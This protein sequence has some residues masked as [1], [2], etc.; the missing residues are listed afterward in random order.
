MTHPVPFEPTFITYQELFKK[1]GVDY[2]FFWF[3]KT[4]TRKSE[5]EIYAE[6]KKNAREAAQNMETVIDFFNQGGSLI[7]FTYEIDIPSSMA[8]YR[9]FTKRGEIELANAYLEIAEIYDSQR[10]SLGPDSRRSQSEARKFYI[11]TLNK[12]QPLLAEI[13]AMWP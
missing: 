2:Q 9:Y 10:E 7:D 3:E 6:N 1:W 11:E 12:V 5:S 13:A 4:R 8:L